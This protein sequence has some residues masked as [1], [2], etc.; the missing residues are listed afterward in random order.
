MELKRIILFGDSLMASSLS[1]ETS[2]FGLLLAERL[3]GRADVLVRGFP[4]YTTKEVAP[5]TADVC[6]LHPHLVLFGFGNSDSALPGQIEH[7]PLNEFRENLE[8]MAARVAESGAWP[9][10]VT[11]TA[12]N[13]NRIRCRTLKA[14]RDYALACREIAEG[15][16]IEVVDLFHGMQLSEDW[17]KELLLSDGLSLNAKGH[18]VLAKMVDSAIDRV[19]PADSMP[20]ARPSVE[21]AK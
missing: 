1:T 12:P 7:L 13:E 4:G 17:P 8:A 20:R 10:L 9:V 2:G 19:I 15:M 3:A 5:L 21:G 18:R 11:P 14:T 6:A 16:Q